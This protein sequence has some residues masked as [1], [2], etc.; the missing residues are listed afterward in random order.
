MVA[1]EEGYVAMAVQASGLALPVCGVDFAAGA[2]LNSQPAAPEDLLAM[3]KA[4]RRGDEAAFA[5]F[6]DLYGFR[7]YK[8]L[9]VLA[10]GDENEAREV[11]QAVMIKLAKRFAVFDDEQQLWAWLR[12]LSKNAFIDHCRARLRQRRLVSLEELAPEPHGTEQPDHHLVEILRDALAGLQPDER[13][14]IQAAYVD[15]RPF[16]ELADASGQTY[17]AVESRLARLRHK[18]KAQVLNQLRH[19]TEP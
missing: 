6:Y 19:E 8:F 1:P 16:Q 15:E 13:E 10:R 14:L 5:R 3:T 18:L 2:S 17:K 11:C 9:L 12:A 4:I 7:L